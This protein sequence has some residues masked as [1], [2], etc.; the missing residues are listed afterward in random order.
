MRI[1]YVINEGTKILYLEI[2]W[3]YFLLGFHIHCVKV[4][5]HGETLLPTLRPPQKKCYLWNLIGWCK[6][7]SSQK[8]FSSLKTKDIISSVLPWYCRY[9][10]LGCTSLEQEYAVC[11]LAILKRTVHML[12]MLHMKGGATHYSMN[13]CRFARAQCPWQSFLGPICIIHF[14]NND[15]FVVVGNLQKDVKYD[16]VPPESLGRSRSRSQRCCKR[17]WGCWQMLGSSVECG[18]VDDRM[19]DVKRGFFV[20]LV[21]E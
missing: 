20:R 1:V 18:D 7:D 15:D 21:V 5:G 13:H 2:L 9:P 17:R 3:E 6:M 12:H 11:T 10:S 4:K 8:M 14:H 16:V 19:Y